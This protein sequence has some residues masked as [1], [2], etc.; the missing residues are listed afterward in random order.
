MRDYLIA[1][2]IV[3]ALIA[4]GWLIF[5][6]ALKSPNNSNNHDHPPI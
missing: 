3:V 2:G 1:I 6:A 5:R 4:V